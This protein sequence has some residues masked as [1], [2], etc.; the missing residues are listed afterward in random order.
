MVMKHISR[1]A[2]ATMAFALALGCSGDDDN[3]DTQKGNIEVIDVNS[4]GCQAT[5]EKTAQLGNDKVLRMNSLTIKLN[6]KGDGMVMLSHLMLNCAAE[7]IENVLM[8]C[9]DGILSIVVVPAKDDVSAN[10]I[11]PYDCSFKAKNL[12]TGH[13][14]LKIYIADGKGKTFNPDYPI[15]EGE[16]TLTPNQEASLTW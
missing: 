6:N 4:S 10:C 14:R 12:K 3:Q 2:L 8:H 9:Q 11:C 1:L 15:Y 5:Y 7:S 13:Y 16:I